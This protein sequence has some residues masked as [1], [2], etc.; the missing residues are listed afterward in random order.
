MSAAAA[1]PD[2]S[3]LPNVLRG[4]VEA[5][6]ETYCTNA[7][8]SL[9]EGGTLDTLT[10]VWGCSE[11][12]ARTCALHPDVLLELQESGDLDR[13]YTEHELARR[14]AALAADVESEEDLYVAL[15]RLRRREAVRIAW[16]DLAGWADLDEV[17][18]VMSELADASLQLALDTVYGLACEQR[19]TPRDEHGK[20]VAMSVLGLGKLGGRELNFSSDI[21]LIFAYRADGDTDAKRS[22]SNHEFFRK[23]A[24]RLI[25][26]LE[27]LTEDGYVFRVDMRLRPNG[28]SGP[29][30][31]S[32]DATVQYYQVHGRDWERYALVKARPVAGDVDGGRRLLEQLRPFVYRKYLDYGAIQAIRDMKQMIDREVQRKHG[33]GDIKLG[34]GGIREIEFIVQSLQLIRGGRD[35]RLQTNR[36]HPALRELGRIDALD[37]ATVTA[38][39]KSYRF[40][41]NLEHRLQMLSDEQIHVLPKGEVD[42]ARIA[43]AMGEQDWTALQASLADVKKQVHETFQR[44]LSEKPPPGDTLETLADVWSARID[45]GTAVPL[46]GQAG[47]QEPEVTLELI[48]RLRQGKSY[49]AHSNVGRERLDRLMPVL[50]QLAGQTGSPHQTLSRLIHFVESVGR[51]STYLILLL[52]NPQALEQLV[53]LCAASAWVSNWIS[54]Y[55]LLLEELLGPITDSDESFE[56][57]LVEEIEH[58]LQPLDDA[59]I[60]GHMEAFREIHH[61]QALRI[62]AADIFGVIDRPRVAER[63]CRVAEKLLDGVAAYCRRELA[64][65]LGAPTASDPGGQVAFGIVGYGKLGSREL[66][67]NSDVDLVFMHHGCDPMAAT[68]GGKRS[69]SNDQYFARLGQRI[70]HVITTRTPSGVLYE[71]DYRL[72]PSGGSGPLVTSL[73]AFKSYQ[74]ERAWTGEHQALVRARMVSG[75]PDLV[76]AFEEIRQEVICTARD[77]GKLRED[78]VQMRARMRS[79]NDRSTGDA[80]DLK[81]GPGGIIDIEFIVQYYVLRYAH[82]HRALAG[83]RNTLELLGLAA[84]LKLIDED[85]ASLL[86]AAYQQY[87]DVDHGHKLAEQEPLIDNDLLKEER[88]Q[89]SEIWS[90]L[91]D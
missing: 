84:G 8:H 39:E 47:Y 62:A 2:F 30:V 66:G 73:T 38:L 70:T 79:A 13:P 17:M 91:F 45:P 35:V 59:D 27:H 50:I 87:L 55:P 46:L 18:A 15:R 76:D 77:P 11:F 43:L 19:G 24:V 37:P 36:I 28:D 14:V 53:R 86:R 64:A 71:I 49:H 68:S 10:R 31:L 48:L 90:R 3:V 65:S 61:A 25:R 85:D 20:A 56:H 57:Q 72:R 33:E 26:A 9:P 58:R 29:L 88:R 42:R 23:L 82:Q 54:R 5:Q 7:P 34:R 40:L 1:E 74:A 51:R 83:P 80:L 67:Y 21:D 78:V 60:E 89:V 44:I 63:L 41:R 6:W 22:L 75:P 81:Q 12:V 52:E 16:R 32:F 4:W 69:V